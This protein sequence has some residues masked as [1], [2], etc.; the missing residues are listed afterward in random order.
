MKHIKNLVWILYLKEVYSLNTSQLT[1]VDN[2]SS[3]FISSF[4]TSQGLC[5]LAPTN[6]TTIPTLNISRTGNVSILCMLNLPSATEEM[7]DFDVIRKIEYYYDVAKR[8]W[9]IFPV[10]L[11]GKFGNKYTKHI[12]NRN[13]IN[14]IAFQ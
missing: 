4:P 5:Y 2:T 10:I 11:L 1:N 3:M 6:N 14:K 9:R 13:S 7:I 8:I 12:C